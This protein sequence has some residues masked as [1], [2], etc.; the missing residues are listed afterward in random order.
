[1]ILNEVVTGEHERMA[2]KIVA[3]ILGA[4]C[5][6]GIALLLC[7]VLLI[8]GNKNPEVEEDNAADNI[9]NESLVPIEHENRMPSSS[10]RILMGEEEKEELEEDEILI[11]RSIIG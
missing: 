3:D 6:F 10:R 9:I 8:K 1:M 7:R 2:F 11:N 4:T 5:I